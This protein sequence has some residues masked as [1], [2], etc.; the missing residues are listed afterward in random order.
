MAAAT[1]GSL[2][3]LPPD[4]LR[5]LETFRKATG[6][7][8]YEYQRE[9]GAQ[10][11]PPEVVEV[12]TGA[13]KTLAMLVPWLCDPNAPRRLVYALPMRSLVEQTARVA[14]EALKR[15]GDDTPV[16]VLMGGVEP[17]DWRRDVDRRA[18][19]IGTVD[20]LLSRALNRGYAESRFA[21]PVAFGLLNNDCRWVMDE[22]QLMGPARTTSSQ[23]HGLREKLGV[24]ATCQTVWMSATVDRQALETI[25]HPALGEVISLS[26]ADRSGPL[27]K[28]LEAEKRVER[29]DLASMPGARVPAAIAEAVAARH[30]PSTRSIVVLNRVDLA[31]QVHAAL[32]KSIRRLPEPPELVL[33]HS[34]FRPPDRSER[35]DEALAAPGP[36]GTILVATQVIE[37]GVDLSSA[38]LA[39]ET[40]PF[41]SIVQRLGRC[42]RA[43]MDD[44]A[45][46][47][48]LDRGDQDARA[49]AP[50]HP[51]DL[52]ASRLALTDLEGRSASPAVVEGM[53]V[54]ERREMTAVL[55][56]RDLFDL[57]DTAPDLSGT[58]IDVSPFIRADDERAVSVF[59][60]ALSELDPKAIAEQPTPGRAELVSIP[61]GVAGDFRGWAFD[62]VDGRWRRLR[63]RERPSPGATVMLDAQDGGYDSLR[64]WTGRAGD[65]P[66]PLPAPEETPESFGSDQGSFSREWVSLSSHLEETSLAA[67][68][69]AHD[70]AL[71]EEW[72]S[73]VSRAAALH[74]IGKAHD[75]FQ[76]MLRGTAKPEERPSLEG[77]LWAKSARSGGSHTRKHFRHELA[78][79]LALASAELNHEGRVSDLV[80]YLVASHHGRVRLSIRPAPAEE[81]P[82]ESA[83]GARYALGVLEGDVLAAVTTPLGDLPETALRLEEMELGGNGRSWTTLALGLREAHGPFVLAFLEVLVRVSDW[84]ASG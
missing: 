80:R 29:V 26:A 39:T 84:R 11:L 76:A 30:R 1:N 51:E 69:L 81:P 68:A 43:G 55:R 77:S 53:N 3:S 83:P 19:L 74:D 60:R 13:G 59:F 73:A 65:V 46:V 23:L 17:E 10:A 8:P 22:V 2:V 54:V 38:L 35:M 63:E 64:G 42:N 44:G 27:R 66:S 12:P 75:A 78:S 79:A 32:L 57:F 41:S 7:A 24:L 20:M 45:T 48:W 70:L 4:D 18:I 67:Q 15:L 36:A 37:A 47:L 33:L 16:H 71:P 25:D 50:Y 52:A 62:I 49:S 40:A 21:W 14:E 61:I 9:L 82:R 5:F 34:R 6:H 58:D 28:R 31:Q 72:A 56:R